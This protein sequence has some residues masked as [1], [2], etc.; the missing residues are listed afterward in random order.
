MIAKKKSIV[1]CLVFLSLAITISCSWL[2]RYRIGLNGQVR[3]MCDVPIFYVLNNV[4]E[5]NV[6]SIVDAADYWN[7][8]LGK[9]LFIYGG[10]NKSEVKPTAHTMVIAQLDNLGAS[11]GLAV[12]N[13][14]KD[15]CV[16]APRITLKSS[17]MKDKATTESL[18]RHELG[19][20]LGLR[21]S[22]NPLHLMHAFALERHMVTIRDNR[23]EPIDATDSEIKKLRE[24]Y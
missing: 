24:I 16:I 22:D 23:T 11:C 6:E 10:Q 15:G 2:P 12:V 13:S 17:C 5:K 1:R 19:H 3:R 21:N 14:G 7:V 4:D 20:V 9:K 18:V 8:A